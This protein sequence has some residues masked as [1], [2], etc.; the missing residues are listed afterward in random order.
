VLRAISVWRYGPG[1]CSGSGVGTAIIQVAKLFNARSSPPSATMEDTEGT[2]ARRRFVINHR[3]EI[4]SRR[5]AVHCRRTCRHRCGHVG[6]DTFSRS[7]AAVKR[8]GRVVTF[9]ATSGDE[10]HIS[11]RRCSARTSLSTVSM[12]AQGVC[13][14]VSPLFPRKL[15]PSWTRVR[16]R[17][18]PG[19]TKNFFPASSRQD[20]CARLIPSIPAALVTPHQSDNYLRTR[21]VYK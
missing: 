19:P 17:D 4:L 20:H 11:L 9:G 5:E 12:L 14:P 1:P 15:R 18:A 21:H 13:L 6:A 16:F 7:L 10:A 3:T 2:G 8:G